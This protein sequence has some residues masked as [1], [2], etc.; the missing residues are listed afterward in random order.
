MQW[1]IKNSVACLVE[2]NTRAFR[3]VL[4]SLGLQSENASSTSCSA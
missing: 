3:D 1:I 2:V 4:E